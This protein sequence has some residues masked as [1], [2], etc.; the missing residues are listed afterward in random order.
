M[1]ELE[2]IT[3]TISSELFNDIIADEYR[4]LL[5]ETGAVEKAIEAARTCDS[6]KEPRPFIVAD[7]QVYINGAMIKNGTIEFNKDI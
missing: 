1:G 4:Q 7:G 5:D 2:D 6:Y 3:I